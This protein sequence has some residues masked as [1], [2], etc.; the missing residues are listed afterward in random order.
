[1]SK[2]KAAIKEEKTLQGRP[3]KYNEDFHPQEFI[4]LSKQ[5]KNITQIAAHFDVSRETIYD[6]GRKFKI[7]SDALKRGREL[8]EAHWYNL[9]Y[10][11]M[12][13]GVE[14]N[15]KKVP[16]NLGFYVWL[17]KNNFGWSDT[18]LPNTEENTFELNFDKHEDKT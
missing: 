12:M 1:M 3:P 6:W 13:G 7:F 10:A 4:R 8:C 5:G 2:K 18:P 9:G 15:G 16:I 14:V 17:T 11:G